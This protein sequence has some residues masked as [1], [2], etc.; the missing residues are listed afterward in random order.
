MK[1]EKLF[2]PVKVGKAV[3]KNRIAMAPMGTLWPGSWSPTGG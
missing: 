3:I 2:D 1:F